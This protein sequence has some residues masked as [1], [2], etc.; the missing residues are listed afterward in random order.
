MNSFISNKYINKQI[1]KEKFLILH[2]VYKQTKIQENC[3]T[4]GRLFNVEIELQNKNANK[5]Y[6]QFK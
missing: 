6:F 2:I 4:R 1:L 3:Y 5:K